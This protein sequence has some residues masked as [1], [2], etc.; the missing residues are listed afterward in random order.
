M[1][2][3]NKILTVSYGTFSCTLEG[4][5]DS[6]GTMKAIA[7]YFRNL[8]AEDRYFGAE[9]PTPDAEMLQ[10]IVE[11]EIHR[12]V[13][14]R[15]SDQGITLRAAEPMAAAV[16]DAA[17]PPTAASTPTP[18]SVEAPDAAEAPVAAAPQQ[19]PVTD[20]P[21]VAPQ[22]KTEAAPTET[23]VAVVT[24]EVSEPPVDVSVPAAAAF[25]SVEEHELAP[26]T[27]EVVQA[28]AS[29]S[30]TDAT[31]AEPVSDAVAEQPSVE[32]P[33][34]DPIKSGR[35]DEAPS[36][37]IAAKLARIRAVVSRS[38]KDEEQERTARTATA[39]L[40]NEAAQLRAGSVA[41]VETTAV[42][43]AQ[44]PDPIETLAPVEADVPTDQAPSEDIVAEDVAAEEA[45]VLYEPDTT[46]AP[47]AVESEA[48]P[49]IDA[50]L[51]I[52][53]VEDSPLVVEEA[54]AEA[55][56]PL[57]VADEIAAFDLDAVDDRDAADG[58]V[59]IED[60]KVEAEVEVEDAATVDRI[61]DEDMSDDAE[62]ALDSGGTDVDAIEASEE[63]VE[64]EIE[65]VA[66][67]E[68]E[69]PKRPA[70]VIRV[71][72]QSLMASLRAA[73]T[74][75][76]HVQTETTEV[77]S[78]IDIA[79]T[80]GAAEVVMA[81][82]EAQQEIEDT[83]VDAVSENEQDAAFEAELRAALAKADDVS[84]PVDAGDE[85]TVVADVE[86]QEAD[87]EEAPDSE[88]DLVA[89]AVPPV[90]H[91]GASLSEDEEADLLAE[92]EAVE[93]EMAEDLEEVNALEARSV[94]EAMETLTGEV[95]G[96]LAPDVDAF[97]DLDAELSALDLAASGDIA[98]VIVLQ[99]EDL[100]EGDDELSEDVPAA[101]SSAPEAD[102]VA[103]I[104]LDEASDSAD[105]AEPKAENAAQVDV[106]D[107]NEAVARMMAGTTESESAVNEASVES[108]VP[109]ETGL[110]TADAETEADDVFE[111]V[112]RVTQTQAQEARVE[113]A[114]ERRALAMETNDDE[115][116]HVTRLLDET[117]VQ[118]EGPEGR[119]RR[120]A[121]QHL[122]AAVAATKAEG[123]GLLNG[124][125]DEDQP[126]RED[127][128]KA[129]RP[130]ALQ[131]KPEADVES[132]T[133][134]D[135]AEQPS[136]RIQDRVAVQAVEPEPQDEPVK[137]ARQAEVATLKPQ[138]DGSV[139]PRRPVVSPN[140]ERLRRA[141]AGA[142]TERPQVA[143]LMLVSEQRVDDSVGEEP[144]KRTGTAETPVQP[145]RPRRVTAGRMSAP[146]L[147]APVAAEREVTLADPTPRTMV[148]TD[149]EAAGIFAESTTFDEFS[150]RMG[151][152]GL[153]E[154]LECAAAYTSY[155]E[156]RP[157]F[158]HPEIMNVV[159]Q[160]EGQE[161]L[162]REDSLRTFGQLLRE[163]KIQKLDRGQFTLSQTSRYMPEKRSAVL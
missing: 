64:I 138:P 140:R 106:P 78:Q 121:I 38:F 7:E 83:V 41:E 20:E 8:A 76:G 10:R 13:E 49:S 18:V 39:L 43:M 50:E 92:L 113:A 161:E 157:H 55:V 73:L 77:V 114:A 30:E 35:L 125:E 111:A 150:D 58:D 116:P 128:A 48:P 14:A 127:L 120:S 104:T 86:T 69:E 37:S 4:F 15:V 61:D 66:S 74:G 44:E 142:A 82:A 68:V 98:D 33:D 143:P 96:D 99:A 103:D 72:K 31:V 153:E 57:L 84:E 87:T 1:V 102:D 85:E 63:P 147:M 148:T 19:V 90:A 115:G 28:E 133:A 71:R 152:N 93:R 95:P 135:A 11:K 40:A 67:D 51:E 54:D 156:G 16:A 149:V 109:L 108:D 112:S 52:A 151:A 2:G 132:E 25:A 163:G 107:A 91:A 141:E 12:R 6:F 21:E 117:N 154:L 70:R 131:P 36:E 89:E 129:V 94:A 139:R 59:A 80:D 158:S 5:D 123:P 88:I 144:E 118:L 100:V 17:A 122:K 124:R 79:E 155:V 105:D 26:Q 53:E 146:D 29:V 101:V 126:Y 97:D 27:P 32:E 134:P 162:R 9:P 42:D 119:R 145:V 110:A 45:S 22:V 136:L 159:R 3:S 75:G 160:V 65:D 23:P 137:E 46:V 81:E 60:D 62:D 56:E 47:A 24:Q 130:K 34:Y